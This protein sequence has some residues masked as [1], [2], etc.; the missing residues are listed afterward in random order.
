MSNLTTIHTL[1]TFISDKLCGWLPALDAGVF[2]A[3]L[4]AA[5]GRMTRLVT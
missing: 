2:V 5:F 4:T 1:F 3:M